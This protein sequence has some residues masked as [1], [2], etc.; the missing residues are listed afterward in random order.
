MFSSRK[1]GRET[2]TEA[3]HFDIE[4]RTTLANKLKTNTGK[5]ALS[6]A[7]VTD[8]CWLYL[9]FSKKFLRKIENFTLGF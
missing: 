6:E 9:V 3:Q 7:S 1:A 5:G 8:E 4:N 2:T